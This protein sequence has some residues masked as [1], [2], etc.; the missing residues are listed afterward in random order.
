VAQAQDKPEKAGKADKAEKPE[1]GRHT[2][3]R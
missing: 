3:R 2:R 1:P